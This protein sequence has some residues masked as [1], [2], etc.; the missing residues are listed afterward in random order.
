MYLSAMSLPRTA[1]EYE[2]LHVRTVRHRALV[3]RA[4]R[5]G[6]YHCGSI[7]AAAAIKLWVAAPGERVPLHAVLLDEH[8]PAGRDTALCPHCGFGAVLPE[9]DD[10]ELSPFLLARMRGFYR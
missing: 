10:V 7:F 4:E 9:V 8:A 1:E 6:C 3:E 2:S 5:C